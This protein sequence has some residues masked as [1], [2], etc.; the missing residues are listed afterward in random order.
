MDPLL[1]PELVEEGGGVIRSLIPP[2]AQGVL[3]KDSASEV[4]RTLT[5]YYR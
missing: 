5:D 3:H 1:W 4:V 2:P